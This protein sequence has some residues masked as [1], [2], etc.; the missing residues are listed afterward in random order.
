MTATLTIPLWA[1]PAAITVL[2]FVA[3][4]F[5]TPEEHGHFAGLGAALAL[6]PTLFAVMLTWMVYGLLT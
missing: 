6:I 4:W 2:C 5:L 3:W 1:I